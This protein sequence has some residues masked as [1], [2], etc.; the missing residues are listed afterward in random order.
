MDLLIGLPT[1]ITLSTIDK[2]NNKKFKLYGGSKKRKPSANKSSSKPPPVKS[3]SKPTTVKSDSK[4]T[5]VKSDSKPTT[6][7]SDSKPPAV[8]PSSD[9]PASDKPASDKP[10]SDK[11][12]SDKPASDKPAST[13]NT[14]TN[15]SNKVSCRAKRRCGHL[16]Q[17]ASGDQSGPTNVIYVHK[18]PWGSSFPSFSGM[19][20]QLSPETTNP[21]QY[22]LLAVTHIV[23]SMV[24]II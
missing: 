4:P 11:P 8:K 19:S 1:L 14:N 24:L 22:I 6:V 20:G 5:T 2:I 10:A 9:K 23:T 18:K 7:K 3:D 21:V 17:G 12:A 16:K 15:N 13:P